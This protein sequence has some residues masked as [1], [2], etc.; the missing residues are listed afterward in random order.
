VIT[1]DNAKLKPWRQEVSGT[2]LAEMKKAGLTMITR[3]PARAV[4]LEA[5]FFFD[6]PKSRR[7]HQVHKI[8]KPDLDKLAR[9]LADSLTGIVFEDD[10]QI[11]E[12]EREEFILRLLR[13]H[14][15]LLTGD[16]QLVIHGYVGA[17]TECA[18]E[19]L[20]LR[21]RVSELE[22]QIKKLKF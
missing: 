19:L 9:S 15:E 14:F 22:D 21:K 12:C 4:H 3:K 20:L 6:P 16:P 2:A 17:L 5:R 18:E 11:S 1:S 8:T 13:K 7:K 10:S